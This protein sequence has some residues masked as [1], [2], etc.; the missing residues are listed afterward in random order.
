MDIITTADG[1]TYEVSTSGNDHLVNGK[2]ISVETLTS[3]HNSLTL[4]SN[5]KVYRILILNF[6]PANKQAT[7]RINGKKVS[8]KITPQEEIYLK[9]IGIEA[10]ALQ[11]AADLKAP[12]PG[13]IKAVNVSAGQ[14]VKVGDALLVL[15]AMKMENVLKATADGIVKEV[16][17]QAGQAVEK[18]AVLVVME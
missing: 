7:L 9:K 2:R 15:E 3:D 11:K 4:Q 6:D 18:N 17:V 5:G 16:K 10:T 1:K 12:M 8:V 13:L 14:S